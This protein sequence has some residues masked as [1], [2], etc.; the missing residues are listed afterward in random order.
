MQTV[1]LIVLLLLIVNALG[2]SDFEALLVLKKG[3]EKDPS[4]QIL[5]SWD[6]KSLASDG[7][8]KN[9]F[10]ITCIDGHVSSIVLNDLG[11]IGDFSF[12]AVAGLKML[13]NISV[14]N[15]QLMGTITS[16]GSIHSLEFLDLSRNNFHG[17]IPSGLLSLKNL[18]F[19]NLSAN[20]FQGTLPSG[21]DNLGR[22]KYL[23]L[24]DNGF[25]GDIMNLVLQFGSMVHLD[26]SRN[27][28]SGSLDLGLGNSSFVSAIQYLNISYNSL[29]GELFA[30]D[31]LPYFDSLEVFDAS[32]NRLVGTIPS[33]NFVVSLRIL[34]LGS[35]Q[36][37][38]SLPEALMQESSM[39]L[40][41]LDLSCNQLE[42]PVGSITSATLKK[43]NLSS[44]KFTGFLPVKVGHCGVVDLSNNRLSGNLSRIQGWGNYVEVIHLSSNSLTGT[45]PNQTSQFLRLTSFKVSNNSIEG[46]LPAI[47]GT[48]PELKVIDLSLNHLIGFLLPSFFTS[49]KLTDLNL[50][51]N[52]FSG[53]F[54][55]QEIQNNPSIG[56]TQDLSLVS[57]DLSYNSLSGHLSPG[58]NQLRNLMYLNLSN[59][60]FEG[61][62]PD[63]LPNDLKGF[64]VSFNNLSGSVPD[65]LRR[66]PES[67][68]HPGNS[69]L[70]FP[71]S[72]LSPGVP[73]LTLRKHGN[74]MKPSTKIALIVGLVGSATMVSLLFIV[75][76]Y[77]VRWQKH[78]RNSLER[79]GEEKSA[80]QGDSSI[81]HPSVLNKR[82]DP[83]LS[84]FS[85]HQNVL[86][87]FQMGSVYDSGDTSSVLKTPKDLCSPESIKK[88]GISSPVSLLSSS[89]PS[90]SKNQLSSKN[91]D[92]LKA[93]SPEKLDGDLHLFDGSQVFTAE[94]LSH[95]PAEVI[96]RSCHGTLYKA[97]LHSG[98]ILAVKW[99]REGIAK[100]RKEFAREVK[101][102]GSIKHPNLVSLKGYYWGPK[103][104][105]KLV[106]SNYVEAQSLALYLQE[107]NPRKLPH[108]S[109]NERLRVAV[110]LARCLNYLHNERAIP[111]GNLKSTNILLEAP[112]MNA[113]LTDY[114]LHRILTSAG[115]AEQ[116]LNAGALGYRPPEFASSSKPCPSLKSDVYAFGVILLELLT[117]KISGEIVCGDPGVV[118][119]TDWVKLLA[120]ESRSRECFD[121]VILDRDGE[122]QP[123]RVLDDM[124]Q[125]GLRC[126]LPASERPDMMSVYEDL[127]T[128][129]LDKANQGFFLI[130]FP[131]LFVS[132]R[133]KWLTKSIRESDDEQQVVTTPA[134]LTPIPPPSPEKSLPVPSPSPPSAGTYVIQIP[135]DQ[136]YRV[137]PP[138]NALRYKH[139][140]KP[141]S[142]KTRLRRCC[143]CFFVTLLVLLLLLAVS[144]AVLYFVF[145][146]ESPNYTVD[147]LSFKSFNLTSSTVSRSI[148]LSLLTTQTTRSE[149][150]T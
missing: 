28:F 11:L 60:N 109:I 19:L 6:S 17:S 63:G 67:A 137:P 24:G 91:P 106:I 73:Y 29:V 114:S 103:E 133:E 25:Q 148:S 77:R 42:G 38:G 49:T 104:H 7:C 142:R 90:P 124:L 50:S 66:F 30:H 47:L 32:N 13:S 140:S 149:S 120:Q 119:L 43:V 35:N 141:K 83:S 85:F 128:M 56:S 138:D 41:E 121:R 4:G 139:L 87:S 72:P 111:H 34:R 48:Y 23:D 127:S 95:A 75:I 105:E 16:I 102:L 130:I 61:S 64:N 150:T 44:N 129:V 82:V 62:I 144:A 22:L 112:N 3:I 88:E 131:R 115:T 33:F 110:D 68:F 57:L 18:V 52:N 89:N 78:G 55:L 10:G 118:D 70:S 108:L 69:L 45:L 40:S 79:A 94:E 122:E 107:T 136:I 71:Y 51:G 5:H 134:T 101:K 96:G 93:S 99:L 15:N 143:C 46:A 146:P 74:Y 31:G 123:A 37:S 65:N 21:F 116:V 84:S 20:N 132:V 145:R 36:F 113:L 135:K 125:V 80:G 81:S 2:Q 59:N 12:P 14:S 86:P 53:S 27:K 97:T 126:I 39:I 100:G 8:P 98:N 76:Y 54:P 26:L 92:V 9:W 1:G 147:D 58:I 117:G